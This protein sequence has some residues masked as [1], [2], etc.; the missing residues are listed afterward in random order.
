MVFIVSKGKMA[1]ENDFLLIYAESDNGKRIDIIFEH[2][3]NFLELA[4]MFEGRLFDDIKEEKGFNRREARGDLGIRVQTSG[5][6]DPT[7]MEATG[8][9]TLIQDINDHVK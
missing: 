7:C 5:K 4:D 6:S 2:Y 9:L 3:D 1:A 8:N